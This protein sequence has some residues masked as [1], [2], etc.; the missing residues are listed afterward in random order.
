[1]DP[2]LV[3]WKIHG[4]SFLQRLR[5]WMN[6]LDPSLLLASDAEILKAHALLGSRAKP[7][8]KD[9]AAL[10]LS[11][12]SFHADSGAALPLAFRPPAFLPMSGLLVLGTLLPHGGVKPALFWQ[13]LLQSYNAGFSY[14]NRNA[15]AEQGKA[16]F[17]GQLALMVGTV[18]CT[19]FAGALPQIFINRLGITSGKLQTFFRY[20]V[21]MPLSAALAFFCVFTV[22][23]QEKETGIQVYDYT[24]KPVGVSK[25]AGEKAGRTAFLLW[26]TGPPLQESFP[27][28][29]RSSPQRERDVGPGPDDPRLLQP[30]PPA[31][32]GG[33]G[34]RGGGAAGPSGRQPVVLPQRALIRNQRTSVWD[35]NAI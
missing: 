21:P 28:A 8:D 31:G 5:L 3:Q 33:E 10:S 18:S 26:L 27:G 11:L 30:L 32:N 34:E 12:S 16:V 25:A 24:G 9:D 13:F 20:M 35:R 2:N 22:R 14:A 7:A 17:S 1:M 19:T 15:S 29:G 23:S 6:L 4:Q